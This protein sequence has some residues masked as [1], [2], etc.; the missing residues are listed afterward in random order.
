MI[1]YVQ[2]R[3]STSHRAPSMALFEELGTAWWFIVF[4]VALVGSVVAGV[5]KL[6]LRRALGHPLQLP[7][8][9]HLEAIKGVS[10]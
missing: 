9:P 1:D 4:N 5:F 6:D 2:H 8:K 10:A 3:P 7:F